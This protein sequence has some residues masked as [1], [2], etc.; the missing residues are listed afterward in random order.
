MVSEML[1]SMFPLRVEVM[2]TDLSETKVE[3][4]VE[5]TLVASTGC[6]HGYLYN[7]QCVWTCTG[8]VAGDDCFDCDPACVGCDGPGPGGCVLC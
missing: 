7:G 6:G 4:I 8:Y 1:R 2:C 5:V 3:V